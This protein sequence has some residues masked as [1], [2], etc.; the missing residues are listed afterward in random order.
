MIA[1]FLNSSS[2]SFPYTNFTFP[3]QH[4]EEKILFVTRESPKMLYLRI[5][6]TFFAVL[7]LFLSG[8]YAIELI[9]SFISLPVY[10]SSQLILFLTLF[11]IGVFIIAAWWFF[12]IW[13]KSIFIITTRRLTKIIYTSPWNK[14]HLSL[15]L[16]KIVDGGAYKKG[17]LQPLLGL[18]Y[19]VARSSAGNIKNFKIVNIDFAEDL[20]NYVTKLLFTFNTN[21][22]QLDSFRPFIPYM[23]GE[24][25]R[26]FAPEYYKTKKPETPQV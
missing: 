16:D 22:Q 23:K 20:H 5:L 19:F 17:L 9:N 14:Y 21:K 25:R 8:L 7:I 18:G 1:N 10:L 13:K 24:D 2:F 3:G 15:N 4:T 12:T 26:R 11:S 6:G